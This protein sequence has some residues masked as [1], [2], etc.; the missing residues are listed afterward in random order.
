[1]A[2][3]IEKMKWISMSW[4]S[5]SW[6]TRSQGTSRRARDTTGGPE[7]FVRK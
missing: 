6:A 4:A 1:M 5:L 7:H 2:L 3:R